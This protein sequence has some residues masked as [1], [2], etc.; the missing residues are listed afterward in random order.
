LVKHQSRPIIGWREWVALPDLGVKA[1]KVKIDT[2]ARSSAIH[3]FDIERFSQGEQDFVRFKMHPMQRETKH[4]VTAEAALLDQRQI[5]N[6]GGQAELRL[7][8]LTHV[9]LK[10]H[11]W[12]IELTLTN[13]DVMGFRM[14][15]GRAAV[16]DHFLVD[17]GHSYLL[18]QKPKFVKDEDLEEI[19]T[20]D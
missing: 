13:R 12:P 1:I 10:D 8:I 20:E 9:E 19:E 6:S 16:R 17:P 3:A 11:R 5:R 2:G 4:T 14:L 15:L 18:S 7:V